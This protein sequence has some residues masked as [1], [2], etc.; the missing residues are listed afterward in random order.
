MAW[1]L[2]AIGLATAASMT[3]NPFILLLLV[4]VATVVVVARRSDQPWARSFRLYVG[5]AVVIVVLRV[6]FRLALRRRVRRH[7]AARPPGGPA[8]RT[9][10][11]G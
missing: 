11:P 7:R 6:V 9:G 2:W 8:A 4:A 3:T 1:W 5:M 10:W